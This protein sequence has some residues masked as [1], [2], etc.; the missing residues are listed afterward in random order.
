MCS[1]SKGTG[2]I[3]DYC[4]VKAKFIQERDVSVC[5]EWFFPWLDLGVGGEWIM[6]YTLSISD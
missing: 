4:Y 2:M 5:I 3:W 6:L 1:A